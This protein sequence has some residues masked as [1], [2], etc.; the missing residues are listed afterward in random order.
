MKK[1]L[2]DRKKR[3]NR[4]RGN[5][6]ARAYNCNIKGLAAFYINLIQRL[7]CLLP[8]GVLYWS[9]AL[10][11]SGKSKFFYI[12]SFRIEQQPFFPV[13]QKKGNDPAITRGFL[14]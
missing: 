2:P 10:F 14:C 6:C 3:K 1:I 9:A 8:G 7:F 4:S 13:F 5:N 11:S 12:L